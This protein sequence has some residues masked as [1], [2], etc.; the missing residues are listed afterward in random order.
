MHSDRRKALNAAYFDGGADVSASLSFSR[1]LEDATDRGQQDRLHID[2]YYATL[3]ANRQADRR[4][5]GQRNGQIDRQTDGGSD[6]WS[7]E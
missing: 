3:D 5:D 7:N 4:T 1:D 6:R 2:N